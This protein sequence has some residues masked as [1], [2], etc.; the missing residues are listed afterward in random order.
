[1]FH[2]SLS[3]R[4]TCVHNFST[5]EM[6]ISNLPLLLRHVL[7][8]AKLN[9]AKCFTRLSAADKRVS[10]IW[11]HIKC[12][13]R[14]C[15]YCYDMYLQLQIWITHVFLSC[16]Q[17]CVHNLNTHEMWISNLNLLLL[18]ILIIAKLNEANC[19]TCLSACGYRICMYC[20]DM[21]LQVQKWWVSV[22]ES[23]WWW[24]CSE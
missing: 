8:S 10:T 6:L 13:Y 24:V 17:A 2:V 16:R 20:Y 19:F 23:E 14:I 22:C 11:R 1:M 4:Q 9:E 18:H 12:W 21:Y 3:C 7:T 15:I 5:N